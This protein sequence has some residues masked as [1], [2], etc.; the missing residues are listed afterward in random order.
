M[1][2]KEICLG[3]LQEKYGLKEEEAEDYMRKYWK[4]E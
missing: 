1:H 3:Q 4:P 2:P